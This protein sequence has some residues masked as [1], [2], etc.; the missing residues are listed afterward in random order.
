LYQGGVGNV[1]KYYADHG[2]PLPNNHNPADWIMAIAQQHSEDSLQKSG[3]YEDCNLPEDN[4]AH[5]DS[6]VVDAL[7]FSCHALDIGLDMRKASLWTQI[8]LLYKR[9]FTNLIRDKVSIGFRLG[10]TAFLN[11]LFGAIFKDTGRNSFAVFTNVQSHFGSII[12]VLISAMFGSAQPALLAIPQERP[13]FLREYSTNHY[14]IVGYFISR[15]SMEAFVT[16]LQVLVGNI[17]CQFLL[18]I[19]TSFFNFFAIVYSLSMASTAVAV[20]LGCSVPTPEIAMELLPLVLVPQMLFAGFFVALS[21]LP[22]W[23]RWI[24]WICALGYGVRLGVIAEFESCAEVEGI[25][26]INCSEVITNS[27]ADVDEKWLYW[28][29]ISVLFIVTRTLAFWVLKSKATY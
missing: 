15:L 8:V 29:V 12:I 25:S 4:P 17:C 20:L 9:E 6:K 24:Q 21:L 16:A 2:F 11:L 19:R 5:D 27:G 26:G 10:I 23:L 1:P 3:F 7:G 22:S 28:V 14:S 18:G 13:L